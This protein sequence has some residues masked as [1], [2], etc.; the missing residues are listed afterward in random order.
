MDET[1]VK[2]NSVKAWI[3]AARPKTLTGAAVPV[4]I[5]TAM[6]L[7]DTGW[8]IE[9][10]PCVL[11][12]FFAFLMQ[13][14]ANFVNDY[15]DF[16]KGNDDAS[17]RLGP[18]RACSMGWVSPGAMRIA[19]LVT[20]AMSCAVGLPLVFYGG[21]DMILV[22]ILCVVFCFLYTISLSYLGWGD[23]L[24]L[25]FFGLVPVCLTYYLCLPRWSQTVTWQVLT[26]SI[27]CGFAID[28]LLIVNNYRDIENDKR[29]GKNTLVVRV[30]HRGGQLL[31]LFTGLVALLLT[32]VVGAT[33]SVWAVVLPVLVYAPLHVSAY[34]KLVEIDRGRELNRV[35]GL[36]A[37]NMF[38]FGVAVTVGF[39]L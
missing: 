9:W 28:A 37:R 18:L 21:L 38:L 5:G 22:G 7:L 3:L 32:I 19:L 11:C 20:T 1:N 4:M 8:K 12:F 26:M 15:F 30:G 14:D 16:K 34:R 35:L 17:T 23:V 27:A 24:V 33:V 2:V 39:L 13:I 29:D 10:V 31:Y 36:T 25:V 6:A